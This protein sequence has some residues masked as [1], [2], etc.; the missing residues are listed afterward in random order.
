MDFRVPVTRD[1]SYIIIVGMIGT[2]NTGVAVETALMSSLIAEIVA[3]PVLTVV[4]LDFRLP[5][6]CQSISTN[7]VDWP[8]PKTWV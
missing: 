5:T 1:C 3:L 6:S 2:E 7:T 4:I 8:T